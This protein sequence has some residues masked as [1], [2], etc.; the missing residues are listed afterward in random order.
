MVGLGEVI[1]QARREAAVRS[2]Q[3]VGRTIGSAALVLRRADRSTKRRKRSVR[4]PSDALAWHDVRL[5]DGTQVRY[6]AA[7][8]GPV[9]LFLHGWAAGS[10]AY[11]RALRRLVRRGCRVVAPALPGFGGTTPLPGRAASIEGY[12]DWVVRFMEAVEI[13]EPALVIGHSFGGG[14]ATVLAHEHPDRVRYLVLVNAVGSRQESRSL[15]DWSVEFVRDLFPLADGLETVAALS[16][17]VVTNV[18]RDPCSLVTAGNLARHADLEHQLN[19]I[20]EG[21]V[22]VLALTSDSDGIIPESAF[23]ALCEAVGAAG[24]RISGG[25]CWL[26]ADPDAFDE[27]L[28]NVVQVEVDAHRNLTAAACAVEIERQ[29]GTIGVATDVAHDFVSTAP[30]LWLMSAAPDVLASDVSLCHPALREGEVRAVAQ[31]VGGGVRVRLTVVAA[32][33]PGL[34]ADSLAVVA[35]EGISV[36]DASAATWPGSGLALHTLT[37]DPFLPI[38]DEQ[39]DRV[40]QRLRTLSTGAVE[41]PEVGPPG[42]AEVRVNGTGDGRAVVTV[43]ARDRLGLLW[44]ICRWFA[45]REVGIESLHATTERGIAI[46]SII[47]FGVVD[48]SELSADLSAGRRAAA[49]VSA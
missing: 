15:A 17:D 43:T 46:D 47:V 20:R 48:A 1:E 30:P 21:P 36:C 3:V 42:V 23:V 40:G 19:A 44:R 12:A 14:V 35:L 5:A 8:D 16:Q 41:C 24:R 2:G 28:A 7:G 22:P 18:L 29:L 4:R 6:G 45:D 34:L 37:L 32:D 10:T 9:V 11:K 49:D 39:W 13:T 27:V 33:R 38:S 26:L 31:P 25:H